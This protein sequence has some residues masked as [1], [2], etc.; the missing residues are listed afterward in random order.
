MTQRYIHSS[1]TRI[2]SL[3]S[4][5]FT[6]EPVT[7]DEWQT[8]DYIVGE[9]LNTSGHL[10]NIELPNGRIME[11]YQGDLVVGALGQRAATLEAVGDWRSI[12]NDLR[13]EA[14]TPAGL[15]GKATSLS[16]YLTPLLP[17]VYKGH[18]KLH[19][20]KLNMRDCVSQT[21]RKDFTLPVILIIGTSMSAG[22][23]TTGKIIVHQLKE[24][25]YKVCAVKLTGAARYRDVLSLGDA[26]ADHIYDF[27]DAGLPS[28]V[29]EKDEFIHSM[30]VLLNKISR[31]E[32]DVVVAEA[33]ASPLEPYNGSVVYEQLRSNI[34][35][36]VLCASDPYAV[37]GVADAFDL[38]PDLV[39]GGATNT[40]AGVELVE[41]LTGYKA[42]N[43]FE[44]SSVTKLTESL[45]DC[46]VKNSN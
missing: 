35:Y 20:K 14:L 25:G 16:M 27:V 19:D 23:T 28:T 10:K 22:K 38:K 44:K 8:G 26:G 29:C 33:G 41:K 21:K 2:S 34:C 31:H 18:V 6:V 3:Q 15:F 12:G 37:V 17:L 11:T 13:F 45:T 46:L 32:V 7:K 40:S 43:L 1:V 42:L 39:T 36:T 5:K 30:H 4:E 9:V 24:Q